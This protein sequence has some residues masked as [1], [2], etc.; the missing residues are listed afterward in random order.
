MA[1]A[2]RGV[3]ESLYTAAARD[4]LAEAGAE[5]TTV[6]REHLRLEDTK[7]TR[8]AAKALLTAAVRDR[9]TSPAPVPASDPILDFASGL[10]D[11]QCQDLEPPA[12]D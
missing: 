5:A 10:T 7:Q 6:L 4:R 3:W 1:E 8:D 9:R 11:E 2:F 12:V